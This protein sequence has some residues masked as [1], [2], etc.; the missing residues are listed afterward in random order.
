MAKG[1]KKKYGDFIIES[2]IPK[3]KGFKIIP[4]SHC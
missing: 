1:S 2:S 3:S 4:K